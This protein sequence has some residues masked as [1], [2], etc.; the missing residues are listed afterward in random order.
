MTPSAY[1]D[2]A[3]REPLDQ[4]LAFKNHEN[5]TSEAVSGNEHVAAARDT[6]FAVA[7]VLKDLLDKTPA[8]RVSLHALNGMTRHVQAAAN[9]VVAFSSSPAPSINHLINA[10]TQFEQNI[11]PLMWAFGP[12]PRGRESAKVRDLVESLSKTSLD[13][14]KGIASKRDE[15]LKT[16]EDLEARTSELKRKLEDLET[17]SA[18]ERA[19]AAATVSKLQQAFNSKE[20]ERDSAFSKALD[21]IEEQAALQR[22][23]A[24]LASSQVLKDLEAQKE[25]AA[26]IVQVVGNIGVTG[27]YQRIANDE[28]ALANTWRW[29]TVGLFGGGIALAVAT[30]VKHLFE[31]ITPESVG[32]IAIRL[33]YALAIAA[34]AWYTARE[35]ARH[36]TNADRARQTEL[37]LASLGPFI[38]LLPQDKK[39]AIREKMTAI[40]FGKDVTPHEATHPLDIKAVRDLVV[41]VLKAARAPR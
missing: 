14:V 7:D 8:A 2:H 21:A 3:V 38:E 20:I 6:V 17:T 23:T 12:I 9:E 22:E 41:E 40:Y 5:M 37:E 28:Q 30:F 27:N 1:R 31:P 36:R 35:S 39:E 13:A 18:G 32:S 29:I 34:P 25:R 16:L 11:M 19:Q 10:A 15:F 26:Q 4:I 33:L 24:E